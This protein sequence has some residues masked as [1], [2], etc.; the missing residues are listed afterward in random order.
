MHQLFLTV[1]L[2]T[3]YFLVKTHTYHIVIQEE[4]SY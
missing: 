4:K 3:H 1:K 2:L